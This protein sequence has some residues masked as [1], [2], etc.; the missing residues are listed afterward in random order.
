[1][2][3]TKH[4]EVHV[5]LN[6]NFEP[7]Y[8]FMIVMCPRNMNDFK[9]K[10]KLMELDSDIEDVY[11]ITNITRKEAQERDCEDSYDNPFI[12]T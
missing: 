7:D 4:V 3:F 1:M 2:G 12:I 11:E 9:I 8:A 10:Q 6:G 5:D